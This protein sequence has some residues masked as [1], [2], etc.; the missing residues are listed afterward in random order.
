M[1]GIQPDTLR[2]GEVLGGTYRV[3]RQIGEG[4]MGVIYEARHTRLSKSFAVKTLHREVTANEEVYRRFRREAEVT[5]EIGHPNIVEVLDF[6]HTDSGVP[7]MVMEFLEGESLG[8]ALERE[9]KLGLEQVLTLVR[10]VGSALQAAHDKGVVH[11]D[12]KPQNIFLCRLGDRT[13]FP[14]VLD[15]GISKISGSSSVMTQSQ[16]YLGSAHYMA[17]EQARGR[18]AD[19]DERTDVFAF[20]SIL[21][22]AVSGSDAFDGDSLPAV[23]YDIVH[24]HPPTASEVDRAIPEAVSEVIRV[25]MNKEP[26]Q[27]F[28]SIAELVRAMEAAVTRG[29]LPA[30][31]AALDGD[32]EPEIAP[33]GLQG[34]RRLV[35]AA[36]GAAVAG[37]GIVA[38]V[39]LLGGREAGPPARQAANPRDPAPAPAGPRPPPPGAARSA[40][41]PDPGEPVAVG[42]ATAP[43]V[44]AP[45]ESPHRSRP[46]RAARRRAA[47]RPAAT[48]TT[49]TVNVVTMHEGQALWA[50]VYLDGRKRGQTPLLL[51]DVATGPHTIKVQRAGIGA[52]TRQVTVSAGRQTDV[53]MVIGR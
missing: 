31:A 9:G 35:L 25:A 15:F 5:S 37:L 45:H 20:G 29:E 16:S 42:P 11:R 7:Y 30:G 34:R 38:G 12:L 51:K 26:D 28:Q 52:K 36:A 10:E 21:Y 24:T 8:E 3:T 49:G 17:P 27:R 14:K 41:P 13:D 6:D 47:P 1:A 44:A 33:P 39:R 53:L 43:D 46:A 50:H 18:S 23:L 22:R 2:I 32:Q 19:A 4:G 48:P 40:P